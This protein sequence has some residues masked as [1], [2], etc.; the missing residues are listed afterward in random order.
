VYQ[1]LRVISGIK[2]EQ[3]LKLGRRESIFEE[4]YIRRALW[5][6]YQQYAS[7]LKKQGLTDLAFNPLTQA[8]RYYLVA[9]DEAQD[10][11]YL[12]LQNLIGL[13]EEGRVAA[14]TDSNQSLMD[15]FSKFNFLK[16]ILGAQEENCL[17]LHESI[18]CSKRVSAFANTVLK[19]KNHVTHGV[20]EKGTQAHL[21]ILQTAIEGEVVWPYP[22]SEEQIRLLKADTNSTQCAIVTLKEHREEAHKLFPGAL[23]LTAEQAKGLEY[24][25]IIAFKLLDQ[26]F[27]KGI[28]EELADF[29]ENAPAASS[30]PKRGDAQHENALVFN[31]LFTAVTR[32]RKALFI[33]DDKE[34]HERRHVLSILDGRINSFAKALSSAPKT[35]EES[36]KEEWL[37]A[38]KEQIRRGAIEVVNGGLKPRIYGAGMN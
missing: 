17:T 38:V 32:A 19:I 15:S 29:D 21:P 24:E 8:S 16:K 23:I 3:Y 27:Y 14:F 34:V 25:K 4:E 18:R 30:R 35:I 10:F 12:Q 36:S 13:A 26:A 2:K 9:I 11:S 5:E 7:H 22:R 37:D 6:V 31:E 1:E 20:L 28:N 33:W